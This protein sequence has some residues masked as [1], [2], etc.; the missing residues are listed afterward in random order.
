MVAS[1]NLSFLPTNGTDVTVNTVETKKASEKSSIDSILDSP[2]QCPRGRE[3]D[4]KGV[5]RRVPRKKS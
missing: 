1:V 5:C 3:A 4:K 2:I